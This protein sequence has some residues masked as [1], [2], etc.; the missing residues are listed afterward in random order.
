VTRDTGR[1]RHKYKWESE[2]VDR[3]SR[4]CVTNSVFLLLE[5]RVDSHFV[6]TYFFL[7][8]DQWAPT[9]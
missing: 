7:V 8:T 1:Q 9:I 4:D 2:F 5:I 3:D 6:L